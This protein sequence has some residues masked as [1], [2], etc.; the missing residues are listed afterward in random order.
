[1]TL[2]EKAIEA[3]QRIKS[4]HNFLRVKEYRKVRPERQKEMIDEFTKD[5]ELLEKT[6]TQPTLDD[7]INVVEVKLNKEYT[8]IDTATG[9]VERSYYR[10]RSGALYEVLTALKG[11]KGEY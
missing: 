2:K 1:M 10:S 7:A 9:Q 6:I 8:Q 4:D 11:L 3:L 5:Y